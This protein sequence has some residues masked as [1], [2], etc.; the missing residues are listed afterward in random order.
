MPSPNVG[1]APLSPGK[2]PPRL[3][4]D[5]IEK[6][7]SKI[8][9]AAYSG[10][11]SRRLDDLFQRF[12]KDSSRF[13][14]E[15]EV[16]TAFRRTLRIPQSVVS[17]LE[18][19]SFC[20]LLDVGGIGAIGIDE[21]MAFVGED[22]KTAKPPRSP[23]SL[24]K[25]K[26]TASQESWN[27]SQSPRLAQISAAR[28]Q[29]R[30]QEEA[31]ILNKIRAMIKASASTVHIGRQ[32]GG[33]FSRFDKDD[34]GQLQEQD[35][36]KILRCTFKIAPRV[37]SDT[38]IDV[39]SKFLDTH[40]TGF[41]KIDA[42]LS[43]VES[44]PSA[45]M[46]TESSLKT[47]KWN[48]GGS[49]GTGSLPHIS[50]NALRVSCELI[51]KG[52][53][54]PFQL[55]TLCKLRSTI[56][57][58]I[59]MNEAYAGRS[60]GQLQNVLKRYDKDGSGRLEYAKVT[61]ALRCALRI[62]PSIIS[63]S[64]VAVMCAALDAEN[65]GVVT[66]TQLLAYVSSSESSLRHHAR[67][68]PPLDT[69][70]LEKVRSTLK[71][72]AYTGHS[73]RQLDVLFSRFDRDGSGSLCDHEVRRA[74]RRTLRIPPSVISD[75]E[76]SSLCVV[77]DADKSGTV[78]IC[79]LVSFVGPEPGISKRTGKNLFGKASECSSPPE[80]AAPEGQRD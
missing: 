18:I 57:A 17:D 49:E 15:G 2:R 8:K 68:A 42:I 70:V 6:L 47:S 75:L 66:V 54:D 80:I 28:V 24:S 31:E 13:L 48:C 35:V 10:P 7:R 29:R 58:A 1:L 34:S 32:L 19:S 76:I 59:S 44:E 63:D 21:I 53:I 74:L 64:E 79:E 27:L 72:A 4:L 39:F 65:C 12:D 73:G 43:F 30:A 40:N 22:A 37:V 50:G 16:R 3:N 77:L 78:S 33:L 26:S 51:L 41:L 38:D 45:P 69:F 62:P 23:P 67:R 11:S 61:D 55:A 52:E 36:R 5:V 60:K 9:A 20:A 56:E 25:S 46:K 71:S 14:E